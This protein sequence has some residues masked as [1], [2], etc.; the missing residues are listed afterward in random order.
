MILLP[1]T[2]LKAEILTR[3]VVFTDAAI[4]YA[5]R[6]GAKG[7]NLVYNAPKNFAENRPQEL[8]LEGEDGYRTVVS[9]VSAHGKLEPVMV[10]VS[11]SEKLLCCIGEHSASEQVKV[12][13]V[14]QPE[15]YTQRLANDELAQKY[16]SAC[17]Y[18]ELNIIPWKGCLIS[19]VCRFCGVNN[20]AVKNPNDALHA[21]HLRSGI[22]GWEAARAPYLANLSES[23]ELALQADCY[24][25]HMHVIL[26]SGNLPDDQ[27]NQ[28]ADIYCDIA[29]HIKN[30]VAHK[31]TEGIVAV[32]TPPHDLTRVDKLK[33]AGVR[34][35]VF[36]LEV[37]NDPWFSKYCPGKSALG[38]DFF[39]D[40]LKYAA[41]VFGRGNSW[42]NFVLGLEPIEKLLELCEE[43]A[44]Y[45]IVSSANVLHVDEGSRLDVDPPS[46]ETVIEFFY[47][48]SKINRRYGFDAFYCAK[49]L[50]TSLS[51]EFQDQRF[52][53]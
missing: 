43:L 10:D 32:I 26:I 6:L 48:L 30:Q 7:Q 9:C 41:Q 40:R 42:T 50:R 47:A 21:A 36:N 19:S 13:F 17:G 11:A 1:E 27:L 28:Q 4:D 34:I 20:V 38:R 18:D 16:I 46:K 31:C 2:D 51:N 5:L 25:D 49:A 3:G 23:I 45:G 35:V 29:N 37:G 39:I 22:L 14:R 24:S 12:S 15:Y 33:E 44:G 8:F 53:L 52:I